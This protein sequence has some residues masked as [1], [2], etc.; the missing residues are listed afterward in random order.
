MIVI[1]QDAW[2]CV[3]TIYVILDEMLKHF[4]NF[5]KISIFS[6]DWQF[7]LIVLLMGAIFISAL[8]L[9]LVRYENRMLFIELQTIQQ[10]RD[11]L[12]ISYGQLQLEHS[13]LTQYKRIETIASQKLDMII[14]TPNDI[15]IA[16][17]D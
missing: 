12:N 9:V 4:Q 14:P 17:P 16:F 13:S 5:S 6:L 1:F 11:V 8:Q 2:P 15:I 7:I 10:Q 3:S